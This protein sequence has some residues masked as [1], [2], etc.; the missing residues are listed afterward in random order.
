MRHSEGHHDH[1]KETPLACDDHHHGL[2]CVR[3]CLGKCG[4]P[5]VSQRGNKDDKSF[6]KKC[7]YFLCCCW[8]CEFCL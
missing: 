3:R 7:L 2:S 4:V 5:V 8:L 6:F 1:G